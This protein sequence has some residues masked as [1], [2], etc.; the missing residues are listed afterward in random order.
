MT[1]ELV[2]PLPFLALN[3]SLALV[4]E[5]GMPLNSARG[6]DDNNMP[7]PLAPSSLRMTSTVPVDRKILA[8]V[9]TFSENNRPRLSP[10]V[11]YPSLYRTAGELEAILAAIDDRSAAC[12]SG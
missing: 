3:A 6:P 10:S 12:E 2:M 9:V 7:L 1:A 4:N 5:S 11:G 8:V